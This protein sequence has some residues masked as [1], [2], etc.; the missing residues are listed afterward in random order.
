VNL[1]SILSAVTAAVVGVVMNLVVWFAIHSI[2]PTR[3]QMDWFLLLLSIVAFVGMVR[4]K[5]D[6]IPVVLG[7]AVIGLLLKTIGL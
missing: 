3:G 6:I 1:A 2:F 7:C 4:W 5:W